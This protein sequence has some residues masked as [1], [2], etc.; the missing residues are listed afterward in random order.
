MT[1]DPIQNKI[2]NELPKDNN[3]K[4]H[5]PC[6]S[7]LKNTKQN[8]SNHLQK[9][10]HKRFVKRGVVYNRVSSAEYQRERFA[11]NKHLREKQREVCQRYYWE[12]K[13]Q[14]NH[15][16]ARNREERKKTL[17]VGG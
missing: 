11:N 8:I 17:I 9:E 10:R 5:C 13:E 16:H 3:K 7:V 1:F 15:R 2:Q 4:Y 6:G 14:I 12:N